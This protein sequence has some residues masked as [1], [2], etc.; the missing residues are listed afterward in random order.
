MKDPE[1]LEVGGGDRIKE[2]VENMQILDSP[3]RHYLKLFNT[4]IEN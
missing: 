3:I 2:M 4:F 1:G